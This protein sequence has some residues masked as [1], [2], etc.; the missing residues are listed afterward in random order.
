MKEEIMPHTEDANTNVQPTDRDETPRYL[1]AY[2]LGE[3]LP[4]TTQKPTN[5]PRLVTEEEREEF[6]RNQRAGWRQRSD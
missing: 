5:I 4:Q 1:S 6:E 3:P 2:G